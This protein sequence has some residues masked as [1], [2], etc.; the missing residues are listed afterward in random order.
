M[1]SFDLAAQQQLH[2]LYSDHHGWLHGWL[3]KKLGN[4]WDAAD[5]AHDTFMRLMDKERLQH[6]GHEPRALITHI[7]KGLII[8]HWR[9]QEIERAYQATIALLPPTHVPSPESRLLILES[10]AR[11]DQLLHGMSGKT[12]K[13]FML[14]QLEGMKYQQIADQLGISLITVKR[15]MQQAFVTCLIAL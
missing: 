4:S 11:I 12:R 3:R 15:H 5:L 13:I 1:S 7:A 14:A 9:H 10:L 6:I 8:D 2:S